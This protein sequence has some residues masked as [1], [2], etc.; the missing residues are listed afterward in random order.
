[1]SRLPG[2]PSRLIRRALR[3]LREVERSPDYEVDM[4]EWHTPSHDGTCAVCL[5]GSVMAISLE[6]AVDELATPG[7]GDMSRRDSCKLEA[8]DEFRVG[9]VARGLLAMSRD[10]PVGVPSELDVPEYDED[11]PGP[12]H[13]AMQNMADLLREAG[14]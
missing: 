2:R 1:M 11:E 8:L 6:L 9:H 12:F 10:W 13:H 3:D 4:G 14:L 5:A 7:H